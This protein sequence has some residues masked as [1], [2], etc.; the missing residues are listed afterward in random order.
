M[1][2]EIFV[3]VGPRETR[4]AVRESDRIVELH[5]ER[6]AERG[7]VGHLYKGRVTRVLPGMQAAFVDIG[8]EKAA[9]LYA[10]DYHAELAPGEEA[11]ED[12]ARARRRGWMNLVVQGASLKIGRAHV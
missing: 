3:N 7:V 10:G 8:L 11:E 1:R 6:A 9:F 12:T 5:F 4:V 2:N